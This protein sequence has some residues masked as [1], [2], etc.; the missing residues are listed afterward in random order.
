MTR[1]T[2]SSLVQ[3]LIAA[4]IVTELGPRTGI[5]RGRPAN[6]LTLSQDGPAALGLE[7]N[8]DYVTACVLRLTGDV[9]HRETWQLKPSSTP[10]AAADALGQLASRA[11]AAADAE[12]LCVM[13]AALAVPGLVGADGAL[14]LA[15]NLK[16][17]DVDIRSL[18]QQQPA[19][20]AVPLSVDNEANLAALAELWTAPQDDSFMHVSGE[21]G[22]GAG[23]VVDGVIYRGRHGWAGELGHVSIDPSGPQCSCGSRGCLEQYAGQNAILRAARLEPARGTS[24]GGDGALARLVHEATKGDASVLDAL[25]QASTALGVAISSALPTR[26]QPHRPWRHLWASV[27]LD[28]ARDRKTSPCTGARR[29]VGPT[30]RPAITAGNRRSCRRRSHVSDPP[31]PQRPRRLHGVNAAMPTQTGSQL[32]RRL[33]HAPTDLGDNIW[34]ECPE[35]RAES[36]GQPNRGLWL[37]GLHLPGQHE[38]RPSARPTTATA[39]ARAAGLVG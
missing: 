32:G 2:A 12:G 8:V 16:W 34:P 21:I 4:G 11:T 25:A 35:P 20:Q 5:Q 17:R 38:P 13:G 15:P 33:D 18:V 29:P 36:S 3:A 26:S 7:I 30:R 19:L 31:N 24:A 27:P 23:V 14:R 10:A 6:G 9:Q 28:R 37:P 1:A 22:I 39:T